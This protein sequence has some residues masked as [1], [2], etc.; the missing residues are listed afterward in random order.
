MRIWY[1]LSSLS[2]L[3]SLMILGCLRVARIGPFEIYTALE[4]PVCMRKFDVLN[5]F[6]TFG[7]QAVCDFF[8][9]FVKRGSDD[10]RYYELIYTMLTHRLNGNFPLGFAMSEHNGFNGDVLAKLPLEMQKQLESYTFHIDDEDMDRR[11]C[12]SLLTG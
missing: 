6:Q 8:K 7:K 1:K 9:E 4:A 3:T 12:Y 10:A 11:L 2:F 5:A